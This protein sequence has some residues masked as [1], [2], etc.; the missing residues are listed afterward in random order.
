M[1]L[2]ALALQ[3]AAANMPARHDPAELDFSHMPVEDAV[4]LIFAIV[5]KDAREDTRAMLSEMNETRKTR[6]AMREAETQMTKEMQRL[7][8][9][10]RSWSD[11]Q[12]DP[13]VSSQIDWANQL[14]IICGKLI[15]GDRE[16]CLEDQVRART[17]ALRKLP[18][19]R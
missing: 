15:D 5:S 2:L 6:S 13:I 11:A 12:S 7:K 3:A 8:A 1:I 14:P 19:P 4:M 17:A 18:T 10:S 9:L 16:R